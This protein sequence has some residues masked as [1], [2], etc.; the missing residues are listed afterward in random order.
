[1]HKR[2]DLILNVCHPLLQFLESIAY[3]I[4]LTYILIKH[5]CRPLAE[6]GTPF[7]LYSVTY[8]DNHIQVIELG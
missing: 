1:M 5:L 3:R 7:T 8:R 2:F 4:A 6:L